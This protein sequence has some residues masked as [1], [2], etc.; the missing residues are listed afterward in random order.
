MASTY[1]PAVH[2][3]RFQEIIANELKDLHGKVNSVISDLPFGIFSSAAHD[4]AQPPDEIIS[5][6]HTLLKPGGMAVLFCTRD[7]MEELKVVVR[8]YPQLQLQTDMIVS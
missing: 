4:I 6:C 1:K 8:R 3:G 5:A 2:V 7:M